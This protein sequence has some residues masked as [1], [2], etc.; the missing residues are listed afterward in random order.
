MNTIRTTDVCNVKKP[1]KIFF[2]I[3]RHPVLFIAI[4]FRRQV[5]KF[6][7]FCVFFC[8]KRR[9]LKL[10]KDFSENHQ[11]LHRKFARSVRFIDSKHT[12]E[13]CLQWYS[14]R[15]SRSQH[16]SNFDN[17]YFNRVQNYL[18][19]HAQLS[20]LMWSLLFS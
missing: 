10:K 4:S 13:S 11:T 3:L 17:H 12:M 1:Q 2:D 7:I 5:P 18:L 16:R 14:N 20:Q 9:D 15:W 19:H 6:Q 8:S